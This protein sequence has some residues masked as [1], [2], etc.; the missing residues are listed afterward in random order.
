MNEE[1]V[2]R[3]GSE[4]EVGCRKSPLTVSNKDISSHSFLGGLT[5]VVIS[6]IRICSIALYFRL[7]NKDTDNIKYYCRRLSTWMWRFGFGWI[8]A[9]TQGHQ[10][11]VKVVSL[12]NRTL[13]RQTGDER[14]WVAAAEQARRHGNPGH[15]EQR[16]GGSQKHKTRAIEIRV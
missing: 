12:L 4:L 14:A 3:L 16:W 2:W 11:W 9:Q 13:I 15:R 1:M 5:S 10:G 8:Q 6:I 7:W